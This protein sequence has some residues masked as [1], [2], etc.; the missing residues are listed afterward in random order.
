MFGRDSKLQYMC[1]IVGS[2]GVNNE[3]D[4]VR[5]ENS[6]LCFRGPDAQIA[7]LITPNLSMGVSRLAMTDPHPRSNQPM[8][9]SANGNVI[10]FNG[11]VYN[12]KE[13]RESLKNNGLNFETE[14][15][16]EVLLKYLSFK[17]ISALTELN[18][19][20]AFALY[21]RNDEKLTLSRDRL[22]KKPLYYT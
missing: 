22:G 4:W 9:D 2:F 3:L 5:C 13:I 21:S 11:E 16:T 1:G 8:F 17:G 19:M 10:S 20:F 15:D 14:S 12:Y 6:K 7:K 18:G